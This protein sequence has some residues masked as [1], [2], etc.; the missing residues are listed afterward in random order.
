MGLF[1]KKQTTEMKNYKMIHYYGGHPM[2]SKEMG[3][4]IYVEDDKIVVKTNTSLASKEFKTVFEVP[5][6]DIKKVSVEKEEEVIR[7]YTATRI[8]LFGPFALAM[9]K[10]QKS[11]KEYLIIECKEFILSF[12]SPI[13][14]L[15]NPMNSQVCEMVYKGLT[16]YRENNGNNKKITIEDGSIQQ[17]KGLK[18]LLDIGAITEEEFNK[19]KK[20]L[21]NL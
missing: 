12:G 20:E 19:K 8:A 6:S 15:P 18:E 7:R 9:K 21:L 17:V 4:F 1:R 3:C 10:K 14:S 2:F 11:S 16:K 5:F 13:S